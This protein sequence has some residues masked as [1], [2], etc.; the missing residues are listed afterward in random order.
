MIPVSS[1]CSGK[2]GAHLP[3]Q[4][5]HVHPPPTGKDDHIGR[6][7]GAVGQLDAADGPNRLS[8]VLREQP[9]NSGAV[10]KCRGTLVHNGVAQH[11][12]EGGATTGDGHQVVVTGHRR[13]VH[14]FGKHRDEVHLRGAGV[15][16]PGQD[17]AMVVTELVPQSREE[18]V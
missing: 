10:A 14:A 15:E 5:R 11:P 17:I 1:S 3:V 9:A 4:R 7:P 8:G 18:G 6:D 13:A 12:L 2:L 16:Q